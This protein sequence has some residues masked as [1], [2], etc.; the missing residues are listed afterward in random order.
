MKIYI[1]INKLQYYIDKKRCY[2]TCEL[3]L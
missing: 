2:F 3:N 1:V